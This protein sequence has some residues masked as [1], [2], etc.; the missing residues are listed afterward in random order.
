MTTPEVAALAETP[1]VE[2]APEPLAPVAAGERVDV[3]DILRGM[4][5]FGIL[6]A[7]IRGFAA[8]AATYF[9]PHLFWPA[10]HDRIAQA[11]IDTFVQGKFI[12]IFALLFGTGFAMQID[13]ANARG[14]RFGWTYVR[15]LVILFAIGL[16]HGLLIWFGDIL[17][18]YAILGFWLLLFRRRSNVTVAVWA[19]VFFAIMP[20]LV[21]AGFAAFQFIDPPALP[22]PTAEEMA[23]A[24]QTFAS[25]S[26]S[27]IQQ[28]RMTDAVTQNWGMMPMFGWHVLAIFLAG[29][30]AWRRGFF[31]PAAESLPRYRRAMIWGLAVGV[32][33]NA[34]IIAMRWVFDVPQLPTTPIA[35]AVM[36]L[37]L[38]FVPALSLGY[39]CAV[40]L[41]CR[42]ERWRARL[43]RFAPVGRMA[44]TNY[45][46]QSVIGTLIFY[47]YGLGLFGTMGP[48]LLL[49][50]TVIIFAAQ[51]A[52]SRWWL[53]RFR[54]GPVEWLWRRLTY[55]RPLPFVRDSAV[56]AAEPAAS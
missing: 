1:P 40:I 36:L 10:L 43:E 52:L 55:G 39:V 45:L 24:T 16:G 13:R 50:P 30:L 42:S 35:L 4:A 17:L 14:S 51:V 19:A 37:P 54:F 6:A 46:L 44:L 2:R 47:S 23:K 49:I 12:T 31:T 48:A 9:V 29:M 5:L 28:Q 3:I 20:L 25:G 21:L 56:S 22:I 26:W 53:R 33:G 34:A 41:L 27:Q 8:P 11:F 18:V 15:R 32:P 7:N 38:L